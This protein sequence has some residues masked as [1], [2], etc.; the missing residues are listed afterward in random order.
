MK[1]VIEFN[2]SELV[3]AINSGVL[4]TLAE[5]VSKTDSAAIKAG[6][7][8]REKQT[9]A[10]ADKEPEK[11][12]KQSPKT[13]SEPEAHPQKEETVTYTLIQVREKLASLSRAGKQA[14]VKA[15]LEKFGA[16][17]LSEVKEEDYA[18]L[19]QDAEGL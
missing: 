19:M 14:Q 8:I 10:A 3:N 7:I 4:L 11:E 18:A 5:S 17:K 9:K 16:T 2:S 6:E 12:D 15:L 1:F 13:N